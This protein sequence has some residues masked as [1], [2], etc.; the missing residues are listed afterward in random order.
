MPDYRRQKII[1]HFDTA[2]RLIKKA[3]G[4]NTDFDKLLYWSDTP[5]QY[6]RNYFLYRDTEEK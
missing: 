2:L 6:D 3:D 4:Y 5:S 1:E